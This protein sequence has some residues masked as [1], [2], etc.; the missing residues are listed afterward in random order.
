MRTCIIHFR[1]SA[2]A[3]TTLALLLLLS[4]C[5][6]DPE[7]TATQAPAP[8]T[9]PAAAPDPTTAPEPRAVPDPVV[10]PV[11]EPTPALDPTA[12][13]EPTPVPTA[14]PEPTVAAPEPVMTL[15]TFVITQETTGGDLMGLLSE[16]ETSCV[17]SGI[18]DALYQLILVTPVTLMVG[19]DISQTAPLFNCLEEENV[20]YLAVAFLDLQAGGWTAESRSCITDVG[21]GHPDAVYVRLGLD[22]GTGPVDPAE[23][24]DQNI[25]I[26]ECLTN[27]EKKAFTVG[28]WIALDRHS[29]ATGADIF[30]L[31]SESEAACVGDDLSQ[32]QLAAIAVAH[33]LEAVSIATSVSHCIDP[34]TNV[35][36]FANVIQWAIGGVTDETLG[37]IKVFARDNPDFVALL[38]SGLDGIMAMP[39]NEFIQ[40]S[41]QGQ[42]QYDCMTDEELMRVQLSAT[43]ALAA[44]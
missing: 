8:T 32:E 42:G 22:L 17:K 14:Q 21:L 33:P 38:S 40:I 34:E 23:T 25:G 20:V 30:G 29:S 13:P 43:A 1:W 28:L 16:Q 3:V 37:C 19:G 4:A 7:P 15:E 35:R 27:E 5:G 31:L 11:P 12:T 26:Y 39:A 6:S 9:A 41:D 36:I 24:L 44:P 10:T 2:I 18:G